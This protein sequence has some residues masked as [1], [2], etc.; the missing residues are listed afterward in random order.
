MAKRSKGLT[1]LKKTRSA[2]RIQMSSAGRENRAMV[3]SV[4]IFVFHP[5]IWY[6]E[7]S[8]IRQKEIVTGV[9]IKLF[10]IR[11]PFSFCT[12]KKAERNPSP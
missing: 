12:S 6:A 10:I 11:L 1:I 3:L 5:S 9:L 7:F 8:Q 2:P 4:I